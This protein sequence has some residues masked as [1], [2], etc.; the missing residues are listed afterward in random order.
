[1]V[2]MVADL[3]ASALATT[4]GSDVEPSSLARLHLER[5]RHHIDRHL[6]DPALDP[7]H[8]AHGVAI[9]VRYLH[10]LFAAEGTSPARQILVG[11]LERASRQLRDPARRHHTVT[12]VAFGCGFRDAAHFSRTFRRHFGMP[13]SE[14]RATAL[15][16]AGPR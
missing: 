6:A 10:Q 4:A 12:Q 7:S 2:G 8:V 1:M 3:L 15:P 14:Y 9:S 13:P 11:R 16:L 5:A